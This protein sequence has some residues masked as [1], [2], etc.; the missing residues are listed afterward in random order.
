MIASGRR[1]RVST[2][3]GGATERLK[4][5]L[6]RLCAGVNGFRLW[7]FCQRLWLASPEL[8]S[9][10]PLAFGLSTSASFSAATWWKRATPGSRNWG[11]LQCGVGR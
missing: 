1:K 8:K 3:R 4:L 6:F 7:Q 5:C 10:D 9:W 11:R 2:S